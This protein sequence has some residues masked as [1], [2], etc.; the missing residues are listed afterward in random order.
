MK[1]HHIGYLV[2]KIERSISE[3]EQIGYTL[4]DSICYDE[5]RDINLCFMENNGYVIELVSPRSEASV[6]W[7]L[8]KKYGNAPYHICYMVEDLDEAIRNFQEKK[9]V[10]TAEPLEAVA[11][12]GCKVAFLIGRDT[13]LIELMENET[14]RDER[15]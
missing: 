4:L 1:I 14:D 8:L 5:L 10:V 15:I 12:G 2:K 9:Y 11:L 6:A 13:G 3:F 7:N